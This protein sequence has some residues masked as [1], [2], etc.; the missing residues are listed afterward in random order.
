MMTNPPAK[1]LNCLLFRSLQ[2]PMW[3]CGRKQ[4][5]L[6]LSPRRHV[7]TVWLILTYFKTIK[8][9]VLFYCAIWFGFASRGCKTLQNRI[10]TSSH[11]SKSKWG[12]W[13]RIPPSKVIKLPLIQIATIISPANVMDIHSVLRKKADETCAFSPKT[14]F[15]SL[16]CSDIS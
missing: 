7:L 15:D 4:T 9:V 14:C 3:I 12:R 16:I 8:G 13:W 6:V 1:S 5:K 2:W 10:D 11:W